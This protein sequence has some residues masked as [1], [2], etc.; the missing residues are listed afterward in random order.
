MLTSAKNAMGKWQKFAKAC[1]WH[2]WV[3]RQEIIFFRGTTNAAAEKFNNYYYY[4]IQ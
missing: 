1:V 4:Q 2:T 3:Q